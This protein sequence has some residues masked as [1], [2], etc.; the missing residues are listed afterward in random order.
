[1]N[2]SEG[3]ILPRGRGREHAQSSLEHHL[4]FPPV[5]R[6]PCVS[7]QPVAL[8]DPSALTDTWSRDISKSL[9]NEKQRDVSPYH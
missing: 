2:K 5:G 9:R 4:R 1:M 7:A 8:T 6:Q 3:S